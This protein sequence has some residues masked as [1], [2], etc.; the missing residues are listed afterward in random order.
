[1]ENMP[2]L[3]VEMILELD[4]KAQQREARYQKAV[5]NIV[6]AADSFRKGKEFEDIAEEVM[7]GL[8]DTPEL[9][10]EVLKW[11]PADKVEPYESRL[12]DAIAD[13]PRYCYLAGLSVGH[14]TTG[15]FKDESFERQGERLVQILE[16]HPDL[17]H[18]AVLYWDQKRSQP[19]IDRFAAAVLKSPKYSLA[20]TKTWKESRIEPFKEK[21]LEAAKSYK[22]EKSESK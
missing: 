21:F 19:Y 12:V 16:R 17:S 5:E 4:L 3:I 1:M 8:D 7:Q 15:G 18:A 11:W 9:A 2:Q 13:N 6:G 20:A 22:P 14:L 10:L